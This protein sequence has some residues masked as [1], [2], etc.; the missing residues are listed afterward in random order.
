MIWRSLTAF[1]TSFPVRLITTEAADLTTK[2]RGV[3]GLNDQLSGIGDRNTDQLGER[4]GRLEAGRRNQL[5]TPKADRDHQ[6]LRGGGVPMH[7]PNDILDDR[8][9][10]HQWTSEVGG[11]G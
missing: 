7:Q 8:Q 1:H 3:K 10:P 9:Q 5:P 2:P 11:S 4:S 6:C